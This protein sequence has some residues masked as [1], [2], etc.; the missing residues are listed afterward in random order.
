M[1]YGRLHLPHDERIQ[2]V[3]KREAGKYKN[4]CA[5][6]VFDIFL[7]RLKVLRLVILILTYVDVAG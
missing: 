5:S 2:R 3:H 7:S 4:F 6:H 1:H